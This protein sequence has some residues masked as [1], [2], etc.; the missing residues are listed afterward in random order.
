MTAIYQTLERFMHQ[1]FTR[2]N[3]I[4]DTVPENEKTSVDPN[5]GFLA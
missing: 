3:E 2:L 4:K 5:V 1:L